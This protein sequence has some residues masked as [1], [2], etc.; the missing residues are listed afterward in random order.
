[1]GIS[2]GDCWC[3]QSDV[4]FVRVAVQAKVDGWIN[5]MDRADRKRRRCVVLNAVGWGLR[6]V[7]QR[8]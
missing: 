3:R 1:M 4:D 2:V 5:W 6:D 8:L 7:S